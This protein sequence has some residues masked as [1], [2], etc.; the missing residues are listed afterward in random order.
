[1]S[2]AVKPG[3]CPVSLFVKQ[4]GRPTVSGEPGDLPVRNTLHQYNLSWI[5]DYK[6]DSKNQLT[7]RVTNL[8][9]T[10]NNNIQFYI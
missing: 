9:I 3:H 2:G 4:M 1:M 10:Y 5:K 8:F 7:F 6:E